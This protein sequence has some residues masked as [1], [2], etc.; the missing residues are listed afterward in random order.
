MIPN[1]PAI[2]RIIARYQLTR[3]DVLRIIVFAAD[4]S[5]VRA[6][7]D[8]VRGVGPAA[9]AGGRVGTRIMP[10]ARTNAA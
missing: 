10:R 8:Y 5:L 6:L 3:A 9:V 2:E 4:R 1:V 7:Y